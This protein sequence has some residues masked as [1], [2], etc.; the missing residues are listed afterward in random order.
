MIYRRRSGS[1]MT[2]TWVLTMAW[3]PWGCVTLRRCL[4]F[5]SP[6]FFLSKTGEKLLNLVG[7]L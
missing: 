4:T 5:L 7:L 2:R 3:Q 6:G 1:A